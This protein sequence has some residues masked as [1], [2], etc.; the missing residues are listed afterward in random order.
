MCI[1][2]CDLE[3]EDLKPPEPPV[4]KGRIEESD[5]EDD[6]DLDKAVEKTDKEKK[7]AERRLADPSM[8]NDEEMEIETKKGL[9]KRLRYKRLARHYLA[10]VPR[11]ED[12]TAVVTAAAYHDVTRILVVGFSNGSFFLYELP[13]VN[14][15]HSLR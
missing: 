11:K 9:V 14:M 6:V 13:E 7:Q 15:I 2:E 4:K 3:P 1:W 10:D 12:N 5:S 8:V